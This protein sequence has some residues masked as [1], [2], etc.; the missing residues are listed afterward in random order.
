MSADSIV[1]GLDSGGTYTRV[2]CTEMSGQI[3]TRIQTGGANPEKNADAEYNVQTA[4]VQ[5]IADSGHTPQQVAGLVAGFARLDSQKD[6]T[7]AERFTAIPGFEMGPYC[8]NDAVVA[9]AGA[10]CLQAGIVAIAGTG[11]IVFG[12]TE[13]SLHISNY[14]FRH[15]TGTTA[16]DLG[17]DMVFRILAGETTDVDAGLV[18]RILTHFEVADEFGV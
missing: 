6:M 17:Y 8:V 9:H 1:I 3:L 4:I 7:W 11:S 5:A 13:A 10:L 12:V 15:H 16:R 14:D 2:L 18:E